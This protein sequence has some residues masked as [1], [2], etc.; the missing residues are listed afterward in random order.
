MKPFAERFYKGRTWQRCR[1]SFIA[2]RMLIDG[3]VCEV[4]HNNQGYIVHHKIWL[5]ADNINNPS[6][7]LNHDNLAYVCKACHD[8]IREAESPK[9]RYSF[10]DNGKLMPI[11][12]S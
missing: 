9:P 11:P 8:K 1:A 2:K 6:I 5:T 10:D 3:G 12:P 7:S 4:C